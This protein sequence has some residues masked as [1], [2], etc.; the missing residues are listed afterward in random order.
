M[1]KLLI[2]FVAA[3]SIA[4]A[5]FAK[6]RKVA[7]QSYTCYSY[8]LADM[9]DLFEAA[10]VE[11]VELCLG[12]LIGGDYPKTRFDE[13]IMER[14]PK[15]FE[16]AKKMF[17]D[18]GLNIISVGVNYPKNEAQIEKL[19]RLAKALGCQ[20]ISAE[21]KPEIIELWLKHLGDLKLTIHNHH[22][23]P[24]ADYNYVAKIIAP[25][26]NVGACADNGG[27]TR[28]GFDSIEG[29]K[30]LKGKIFT[31]HLK[32]QEKLGKTDS[33][34]K[35]YGTG[36]IDLKGMLAELDAQ[37]FDGYLIIEHGNYD[38]KYQVIKRDIEFLKNN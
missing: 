16:Y 21:S 22:S 6:D 19:C 29:L 17:K 34:A 30:V 24:F 2:L 4:A 9:C 3:L 13:N 31:V 12:Q 5:A 28:A 15:A 14:D 11:N 18:H 1:K 20:Y 8:N 33:K 38:D 26:S 25:Y 27:W 37:N 23:L 7:V 32:D 36:C 10:G 35:I